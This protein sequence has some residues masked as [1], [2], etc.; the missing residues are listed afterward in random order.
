[1]Y[2]PPPSAPGKAG[3]SALIRKKHIDKNRLEVRIFRT[4]PII[5]KKVEF[6]K[7]KYAT[8]AVQ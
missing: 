5:I 6:L 4:I 1:V 7:Y 2:I 8:S 3:V